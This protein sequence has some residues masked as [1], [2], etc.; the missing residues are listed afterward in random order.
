MCS[1]SDQMMTNIQIK[2]MIVSTQ[3]LRGKK[4][5]AC[6]DSIAWENKLSIRLKEYIN[7]LFS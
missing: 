1:V 7:I 3:T 5:A 4:P 6:V 2:T